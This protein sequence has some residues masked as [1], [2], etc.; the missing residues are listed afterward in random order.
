MA[1]TITAKLTLSGAGMPKN[2][3]APSPLFNFKTGTYDSRG[4]IWKG[5]APATK[6][7]ILALRK[8]FGPKVKIDGNSKRGLD[9]PKYNT[10]GSRNTGKGAYKQTVVAK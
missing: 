8:V 6:V 10:F 1:K 9:N 7:D 5:K 4:M 2:W 3:G